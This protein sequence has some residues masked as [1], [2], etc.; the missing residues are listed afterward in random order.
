MYVACCLIRD[1]DQ[2]FTSHVPRQLYKADQTELPPG[3]DVD[4]AA[5]IEDSS[6]HA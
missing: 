2:Y 1:Y 3:K 6:K 4:E 5:H